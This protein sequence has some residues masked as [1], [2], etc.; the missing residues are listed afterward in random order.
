MIKILSLIFTMILMAIAS[1][2]SKNYINPIPGKTWYAIKIFTGIPGEPKHMDLLCEEDCS[3]ISRMYY[4]KYQVTTDGIVKTTD[5]NNMTK[6]Y[7]RAY[8][9]PDKLILSYGSTQEEED[10]FDILSESDDFLTLKNKNDQVFY[11]ISD[12]MY[13]NGASVN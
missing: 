1:H 8:I 5:P 3:G 2:H 6:K 13:L 9:E 7:R 10:A 12:Y 4:F 11:F